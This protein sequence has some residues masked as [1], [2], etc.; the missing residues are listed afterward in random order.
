MLRNLEMQAFAFLAFCHL[1]Q[2]PACHVG[3]LRQQQPL[4]LADAPAIRSISLQSPEFTRVCSAYG[5]HQPPSRSTC[6]RH[7][8]S[9][10]RCTAPQVSTEIW[11]L[12]AKAACFIRH[13][14][15]S[16]LVSLH[17]SGGGGC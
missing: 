8:S 2:A 6:S 4:L 11:S 10:S 17:V 13:P 9:C 1:H 7:G 16:K 12:F 14:R 15:Q 3:G 5:S